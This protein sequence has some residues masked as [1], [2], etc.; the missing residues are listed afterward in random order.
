M[1]SQRT[2]LLSLHTLDLQA[3]PSAQEHAFS[4]RPA[5]TLTVA[6]AQRKGLNKHLFL[7][8]RAGA[9]L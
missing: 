6:L 1:F 9:L 3:C 7:A 5:S 4:L 8:R 2:A